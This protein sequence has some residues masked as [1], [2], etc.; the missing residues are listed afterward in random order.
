MKKKI[1]QNTHPPQAISANLTIINK[2]LINYTDVNYK[3][4]DLLWISYWEVASVNSEGIRCLL[5]VLVSI[6][7]LNRP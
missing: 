2:K 3:E 1:F 6:W 7:F 4:N 5:T